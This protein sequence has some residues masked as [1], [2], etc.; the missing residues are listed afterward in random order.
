MHIASCCPQEEFLHS[1]FWDRDPPLNASALLEAAELDSKPVVELPKGCNL[2]AQASAAPAHDQRCAIDECLAIQS[3]VRGGHD[4]PGAT[5]G[6][7]DYH[8]NGTGLHM[9]MIVLYNCIW[10]PPSLG[11]AETGTA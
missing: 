3:E 7:L 8:N 2:A 9:R 5:L 4:Q 6:G 11:T 10:L 1:T